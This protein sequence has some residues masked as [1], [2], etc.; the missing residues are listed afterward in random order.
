MSSEA[1]V[2][3][4]HAAPQED[5]RVPDPHA[6]SGRPGG[7]LPPAP[8][9]SGAALGLAAPAAARPHW[10]RLRRPGEFRRVLR[11]GRSR[12]ARG[13][14]VHVREQDVPVY[15]D[16]PVHEDL[17]VHQ[18]LPVD[19]ASRGHGGGQARLGL[20]VPKA[21]GGAVVRNRMK[22]RLRAIWRDLAPAAAVDCVI[23]VRAEAAQLSYAELT[24]TVQRCLRRADGADRGHRAHRERAETSM[25]VR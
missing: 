8:E 17:R 23:V 20:V 4:E 11:G 15:E 24:E 12:S 9:G 21:V 25:A 16:V 18:D 1:N 19:R 6:D 2:P 22:R 14:V 7:H 13:I 10:G 3:A 5:P